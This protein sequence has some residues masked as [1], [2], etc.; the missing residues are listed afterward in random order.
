MIAFRRQGLALAAIQSVAAAVLATALV[1][2]LIA[3]LGKNP[4]EVLGELVRGPL[5]DR[6]RF[7]EALGR[8]CPLMLC[9]LAVAFAFQAQAWNIGVEGQ[10][11]CGA[12]A[13]TAIGLHG[14]TWQGAVLIPAMLLASIVTGAAFA[15][16]AV[17]LENLRR[18][19]L[20][21][22][23]ILLNFVAVSLVSYLTQGPMRGSDPSA[24]Q[25]DPIAP[26][27]Y[28]LSLV[29]GTDCHVG[30]LIACAIAL[31]AAFMLRMT[32]WGFELRVAGLNPLAGEW[33]GIRAARVRLVTMLISGGLGGLAG[34]IQVAGVTHLLNIQ[35]SEGFGYVG[36]AVALLGRLHPLGVVAAAV[37]LGMLDIGASHVER[38]ARLGV[39]AD[40]AQVIKGVLVLVVLVTGSGWRPRWLD[41]LR[42]RA[43]APTLREGAGA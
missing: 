30:L 14:G 31:I 39:P 15:L 23:T 17:L 8:S 36:I 20:V 32:I 37:A 41:R 16:P 9:G 22:S 11:L 40:I 27:G 21:L 26:Q 24:A 43:A 35:A 10:Y 28:L 18:V 3:F 38:Q 7:A 19:P 29:R 1:A 12:I 34:G 25:T 4:L 2:G 33:A 13:A 5:G 6:H 42:L